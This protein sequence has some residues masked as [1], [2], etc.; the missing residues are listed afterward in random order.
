MNKPFNPDMLS[1]RRQA[2][3]LTHEAVVALTDHALSQPTLSRIESGLQKPSPDQVEVI[4]KALRVRTSFFYHQL[5]RR[6]MPP[7][8]HRKRSKLA[9]SAWDQIFAKAETHRVFLSVML[10]SVSL[11][12][13]RPP[14]PFC[15]LDE[16]GGDVSEVARA[17]RQ[18]FQ[19]PRG[20]IAD[21]TRI[22]ES[23]GVIVIQM[24]FGT[25]LID[26]F[27]QPAS[28]NLPPIIYVNKR[29]KLDRLRF[30]IGHELGHLILHRAP[31]PSMEDEA[32]K[33]SAELLMPR[34][35]IRHDLYDLSLEKFQLLK[36]KWKVAMQ[37][38]VKRS[39]DIGRITERSYRY[40]M[41]Q[42]V[43]KW[44]K[45]REPIDISEDI[46]HP[47]IWDQLVRAHTGTLGMSPAELSELFGVMEPE[48]RDELQ[49]GERPKL[50][51]VALS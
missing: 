48:V 21:L 35:D 9:G 4:A 1:I 7:T 37:A 18:Y 43:Q 50:R 31:Q 17:M 5:Y 23:T 38:L 29:L 19:L 47:R 26:G 28:E 39:H 3:G 45:T 32:N 46:E 30:T 27:S 22:V 40:Y 16:Y 12:P 14:V 11:T 49:I 44:G 15:D 20:P 13:T 10:A 6:A 2:L 36:L 42:M 51:L 25:D 34:D 24:D 33:F 41:M 8:F